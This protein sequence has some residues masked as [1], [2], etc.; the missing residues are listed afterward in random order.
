[1][2]VDFLFDAIN[3]RADGKRPGLRCLTAYYLATLGEYAKV[4]NNEQVTL[5]KWLK[6]RGNWQH[7]WNGSISSSDAPELKGTSPFD[8]H[9]S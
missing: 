4:L 3:C 1:M 9:R 5:E 8:P 2:L 6:E 7:I